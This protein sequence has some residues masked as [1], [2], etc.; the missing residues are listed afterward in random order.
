MSISIDCP[1]CCH[2]WWMHG[3]DGCFHHEAGVICSCMVSN[4]TTPDLTR[5]YNVPNNDSGVPEDW[6]RC[7]PSIPSILVRYREENATLRAL[8]AMREAEAALRSGGNK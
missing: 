6:I 7:H 8:L 4:D 5:G 3:P 1:Q 2:H